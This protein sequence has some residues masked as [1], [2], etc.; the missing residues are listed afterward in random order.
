[1][2]QVRF[3]FPI[4]HL[5]KSFHFLHEQ[6]NRLRHILRCEYQ[7]GL[8][9]CIGGADQAVISEQ[10]FAVLQICA[11]KNLRSAF[12]EEIHAVR[13]RVLGGGAV[14]GSIVPA[15]L[16]VSK[17]ICTLFVVVS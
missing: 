14:I 2:G 6:R 5:P 11:G 8:C 1:M 17:E 7:T 12:N 3:V 15:K 4:L 16:P 10:R 9:P 13:D